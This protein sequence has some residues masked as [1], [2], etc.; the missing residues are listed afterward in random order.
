MLPSPSIQYVLK[1]IAHLTDKE[2]PSKQAITKSTKLAE[3]ENAINELNKSFISNITNHESDT[4]NKINSNIEKLNELKLKINTFPEPPTDRK[5]HELKQRV[6]QSLEKAEL[7]KHLLDFDYGFEAHIEKVW[8]ALETM[9]THTWSLGESVS[10]AHYAKVLNSLHDLCELYT[11]H[12]A[13][14]E[15]FHSAHEY[16][17][18]KMKEVLYQI[19]SSIIDHSALAQDRFPDLLEERTEEI[20]RAVRCLVEGGPDEMM[21]HYR[22]FSEAVKKLR[23]LQ[24]Q[25]DTAEKQLGSAASWLKAYKAQPQ[26]EGM[27][28]KAWKSISTLL[29]TPSEVY[30]KM[31]RLA[32]QVDHDLQMYSSKNQELQDKIEHLQSRI[33]KTTGGFLKVAEGQKFQEEVRALTQRYAD[34]EEISIIEYIDIKRQLQPLTFLIEECRKHGIQVDQ[35]MYEQLL[36]AQKEGD[37]LLETLLKKHPE[38]AES[39]VYAQ[40]EKCALLEEQWTSEK[41]AAQFAEGTK[42]KL[43]LILNALK[44]AP[45]VGPILKSTYQFLTE[46]HEIKESTPLRTAELDSWMREFLDGQNTTKVSFDLHPPKQVLSMLKQI[47]YENVRMRVPISEEYLKRTYALREEC[48][49]S[50]G[51]GITS[52]EAFTYSSDPVLCKSTDKIMREKEWHPYRINFHRKVMAQQFQDVM[53]LSYRMNSTFPKT[54]ALRGNTAS[55]KTRSLKTDPFFRTLFDTFQG[56]GVINPDI[57]KQTLRTGQPAVTHQQVHREGAMLTARLVDDIKKRSTTSSIIIDKRLDTTGDVETTLNLATARHSQVNFFDIDA[58]LEDSCLRVLNRNPKG[59]DPTVPFNAIAE[60]YKGIRENRI[61]LIEKAQNNRFFG[62]YKLFSG[63][64]LVAEIKEGRFTIA[65]GKDKLFYQI[66]G[67]KPDQIEQE[68]KEVRDRVLTPAYVQ[69]ILIDKPSLKGI[70]KFTG[71]TIQNAL[72]RLAGV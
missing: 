60:G 23:L 2:I 31:S 50:S 66:I 58:P 37:S 70:E 62:F 9:N 11:L 28:S 34:Q 68:I 43:Y 33:Q 72:N 61:D 30:G 42:I 40:Q 17:D 1:D 16:L 19:E 56:K 48:L 46:N 5:V 57:V 49:V 36:L 14:G 27:L 26:S 8:D 15:E 35:S 67:A 47:E 29:F 65:P 69:K 64:K 6:F 21:R 24:S 18:A 71:M 44:L 53:H 52:C 3:I 41:T 39:D 54:Y 32:D 10:T 13:F 22:L 55:G 59:E 12:S 4:I 7:V 63:G 51:S 38:Y 45:K 25:F 20:N